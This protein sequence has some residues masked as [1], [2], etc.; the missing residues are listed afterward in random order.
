MRVSDNCV[1]VWFARPLASDI[2]HDMV[3][4][5]CTMPMQA[6][7]AAVMYVGSKTRLEEADFELKVGSQDIDMTWVANAHH[8][9]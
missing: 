5:F 2:S 4:V 1:V 3:F 8:T 9:Q 7:S 6:R